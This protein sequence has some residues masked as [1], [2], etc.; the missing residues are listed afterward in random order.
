LEPLAKIHETIGSKISVSQW[1]TQ[2]KKLQRVEHAR[3]VLQVALYLRT[4]G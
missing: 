2:M 1:P 3:E 4:R